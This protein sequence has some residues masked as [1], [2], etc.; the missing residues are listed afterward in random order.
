MQRRNC[1]TH[2]I[3]KRFSSVDVLVGGKEALIKSQSPKWSLALSADEI[4]YLV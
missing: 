3:G 4:D 1:S 2:P